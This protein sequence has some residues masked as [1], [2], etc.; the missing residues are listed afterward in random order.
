MTPHKN[1]DVESS[2]TES[3]SS[4]KHTAEPEVSLDQLFSELSKETQLTDIPESDEDEFSKIKHNIS[5]LPEI[6]SNLEAKLV[7]K[8]TARPD[9]V[10]INDPI[11]L[12][13]KVKDDEPKDAGSKWFGMRQPELT[14]EIKRDLQVIKHR[15]A[16][17]PK[18]HYKKEKWDIPKFFQTGTIIEGNTEYYSSRMKRKDR[19]N[20]LVEEVLNDGDANK[21]FKRKF[22]QIQEAKHSGKKGHYKKVKLMRKRF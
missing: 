17:D 1:N 20:T 13:V 3:F 22:S 21:Y 12:K 2:D 5:K 11:V 16:L 14:P 7:G 6:K 8:P 19:G 15:S 4:D 9:I 10:R 18:R